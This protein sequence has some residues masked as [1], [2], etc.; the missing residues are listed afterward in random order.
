[1]TSRP[2]PELLRVAQEITT[3]ALTIDESTA[4]S[5]FVTARCEG[6][7]LLAQYVTGLLTDELTIEGAP[8]PELQPPE[9][10]GPYRITDLIGAGGMGRVYRAEQTEPVQR[11]VAIKFM[12]STVENAEQKIRFMAERQALAR[13]SHPNIAQLFDAGTTQE[14]YP[15]FVM[16]FVEG[17]PLVLYADLCE[18][19]IDQR[20]QLFL[21]VCDGVAHAH[22]KGIL[23]RDLKPENILVTTLGDRPTP[24]IIDFGIAKAVDDPLVEQELHSGVVALGT[25]PYMSP[26]ALTSD[27]ES[28]D[29][30]VR[31][32]VYALGV[33]LYELLT[34]RRP[35]QRDGRSVQRLVAEIESGDAPRPSAG[36]GTTD[37]VPVEELARRRRLEPEGLRRKLADDLDWVV[38]RAIHA[39]R[40]QRYSS[41]VD[42]STDIRRYLANQP[43]EARPPTFSYRATK[44]VR[45][46]RSIV[47]ATVLALAALIGGF[48]AAVYGL[49]TARSAEAEA[50]QQA[51]NAAEQQAAAEAAADFLKELFL[52]IDPFNPG[53]SLRGGE[54]TVQE[55][56]DQTARRLLEDE[57]AEQPRLRAQLM[58]DLGLLYLQLGSPERAEPLLDAASRLHE[59]NQFGTDLD[60]ADIES[61]FGLLKELRGD[62]PAAEE[63]YWSAYRIALRLLG[64]DHPSTARARTSLAKIVL[65][66]NRHDAAL[67]LLTET[68]ESIRRSSGEANQDYTNALN[69]LA[70]AHYA[71]EDYAAAESLFRDSLLAGISY[72]EPDEPAMGVGHN[73]LAMAMLMQGKIDAAEAEI[74]LAL[75]IFEASMPDHWRT[76]NA[77]T[78]LAAC[79]I[80]QGAFAEAEALLVENYPRVID[81]RGINSPYAREIRARFVRLYDAQGQPERAAPYRDSAELER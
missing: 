77:R 48:G 14:G 1:M 18:L 7:S 9:A 63:H 43:V 47:L 45:R 26:E 42:L 37:D 58:S 64:V 65:T 24:K 81:G 22:L 35:Y 10:I 79:R 20:L 32:D 71:A 6:N 57:L 16:E 66:Q 17:R 54:Q 61:H 34:G 3:R 30:D 80:E 11:Q 29:E 67:P 56:I 51:L 21:A 4:R 75:S 46:N 44:F 50:R 36:L 25:A 2:D 5:D 60:L 39:D 15:Y 52:D 69:S 70:F 41:V 33:V 78:V 72:R 74:G 40:D 55:L 59:V 62:Y 53:A 68:V 73:N 31:S 19:T 28:R 12:R 13:L 38:M 76:A 49:L 27:P 8:D 23:H